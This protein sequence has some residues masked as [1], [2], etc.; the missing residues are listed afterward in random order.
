MVG[1]VDEC[2]YAHVE[3]LLQN[4]W[5]SYHTAAARAPVGIAHFA[6]V[7]LFN[8]AAHVHY[9]C[10]VYV[11]I[12]H[13]DKERH[14]FEHRPW[15]VQVLYSIGIYFLIAAVGHAA[16][17]CHGFNVAGAHLHQYAHARVGVNLGKL[18]RESFFADVLHAY[19]ECGHHIVAVY[20]GFVYD[21]KVAVEH[22]LAVCRPLLATQ[23][24]VKAQ[25]KSCARFAVGLVQVANSTC[26][27]VAER[28]LAHFELFGMK[29]A[30]IGRHLEQRQ[31][32][33]LS[34]GNIRYTL[35]I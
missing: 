33:E 3:R 16:Q 27:Q 18:V 26:C 22:L 11:A 29:A 35:F 9:I 24:R 31:L 8:T 10:H 2:T 32:L 15:L 34:V 4:L 7:H 17:T 20:G 13:A 1:A 14:G 19:V 5:H 12:V 30:H 23:N 6:A 28:V 25:L 21:G